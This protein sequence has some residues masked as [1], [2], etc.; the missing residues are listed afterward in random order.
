MTEGAWGNWGKKPACDANRP[1][2]ASA[3]VRVRLAELDT[4]ELTDILSDS[5]RQAA[6]PRL[7]EEH[8]ALGVP[9][10]G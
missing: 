6:P 5:W 3:W 9:A 1:P 4:E 8:P 10:G 7:L 2:A